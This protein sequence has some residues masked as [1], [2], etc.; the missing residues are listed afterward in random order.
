MSNFKIEK[1]NVE[2]MLGLTSMQEGMLF[3]YLANPGSKQYFE[4]FRL[5]LSGNIDPE[6][7][8]KAWEA[9][10]QTNEMLRTV[11][12]WEKLE[13]PIQVVL[14]KKEI[15]IEFKNLE[16]YGAKEKT[17]A[18][19]R[20]IDEDMNRPIEI[21][22]DPL[23]ITLIRMD[24]SEYRM[25]LT[26]HHIVY[27]GWSN[28][29][30][31]T[32]FLDAYH[33]LA[34]IEI[35]ELRP[36]SGS[37]L[38]KT[39]YKE[40]FKW[41]KQQFMIHNKEERETFW[42]AYLDGFDTCTS[43]PYNH[44][45]L[46][47]ISHVNTYPM[48]TDPSLYTAIET[49]TQQQNI[50]LSVLLYTA[51]GILL[52]KY[53]NADD[54]MFGTTVSGRVP[55][56][57][58]IDRMVGLFINTL[59]LRVNVTGDNSVYSAFQSISDHSKE[60]SRFEHTPL[61]EIKKYTGMGK[62]QDLFDSLIVI[63]NYPLAVEEPG[64]GENSSALKV[65]AFDMF[66][67][68]SFDITVQ[69]LPF[70]SRTM[71]IRFHFNSDLFEFETIQ[72]M[73]HH[74]LNVL[75]GITR[76][77]VGEISGI[78]MLSSEERKQ[79]LE[80]FNN[81]EVEYVVDKTVHGEIEKQVLRVPG[82]KAVQYEDKYITYMEFDTA[83]NR[84][85]HM[86]K[87]HGIKE[88]SRVAMMFPRSIEMITAVY[89]ILK[90]GAACIPLDI[91]YPDERNRFIVEDSGATILLKHPDVS[92]TAEPAVADMIYDTR[93]LMEFPEE[94]PG[95]VVK[96]TDLSYI[97]YTSGS[98]GKPKGAL[99][100]HS[101]IVNHT[102]TKIG[103]LGIT[104]KDSVGN[105]FSINVIASIW[106]ILS[107]LFMG[108]RLV[109][110]SDEIE[111]DPYAQFKRV[112]ED[113]VTVIEVIP[114]VLKSYLF[115]LEEGKEVVNLDGLR[116]VALTSEETKPFLVNKFYSLYKN[117]DMVDCYG[118]TECSDDVLHYTIPHDTNTQK[119]PI[120]TPSLNTQVMVLN[121]HNQLQPVGVVGEICVSGAGVCYGYWNRP[122]MNEEK[123]VS[124]PLNPEIRMYRT[125]DLGCWM[126][127]GKV[128]YLGRI[129]HQVKIRGNRVE[130]REIENRIIG[131]QD[132]KEA[133][134]VVKED[135]EGDKN[136]FCFF[137]SSKEITSP[138]IR[139]YLLD[140]LPDYMVPAHFIQLEKLPYTPNGKI[141]RKVLVKMEVETGVSTGVD[142][143]PPRNTY[144]TKI[145]EIWVQL[146][147]KPQIGMND[148]FFDLGGHS[149]LLI[150][151]KSKL[152][153][154]FNPDREISIIELFNYPTI[155]HQA[156][157]IQELLHIETKE[158]GV[159]KGEEREGEKGVITRDEDRDIAVIGISLKIPG[160]ASVEEFW[161]NII[162]GVESISFFDDGEI[163][164]SE[165]EGF[166]KGRSKVVN[167]GGIIGD[168]ELF[169]ADFFGFNPRE[170]EII[171]PQQ[172]L[173]L[174]HSWMALE[175]A[176]YGAIGETYGGNV[177]VYA[178]VGL[179]TYLL[180]NV[181]S[182]QQVV[183]T[184][185]EFQTMIGNDKD[186]LSTRVAYKLNLRG[187]AL[188]VQCACST[189]LVAVHLAR[190]GILTG[191][192]D[193]ALVG[194]VAVHVPEKTGYYYNEG[195]YLSPD[196]H[197]RAFDKDAQGTV[198]GNGIG[199]V[200]LKRLSKA[201]RDRDS[202][203]GIVKGSAINNDGSF[204]VGYTSPGETG[205]SQVIAKAIKEA[206][207]TSDTIGF[208]E[209][210][211]TGTV[212]GDPVEISALTRAHRSTHGKEKVKNGYCA[213]GSLKAN[214]GHL[215]IAAGIT[216]FIKAVLCLK[217]KKLPASINVTEPNPMIDFPNTPFYVNLTAKDWERGETPRRAGVSSFGIGGTNAH[218]ILEEAPG[219]EK[220]ISNTSKQQ[221]HLL[222]LSA[223]TDS[224]LENTKNRFVE[225]LK[226]NPSVDMGDVAN[227]LSL[228]RKAF[229]R[230]LAFVCNGAEDAREALETF[231][232]RRMIM[233]TRQSGEKSAVFMFPGIGEHYVNMAVGLYRT[234]PVFRKHVDNCC[235]LL[236]PLL[237]RDLR[238]I[239]FVEGLEKD[240]LKGNTDGA[241]GTQTVDFRKLV[242]TGGV[243]GD[244]LSEEEKTLSQT[245]YAH[246]SVFVV[247]Y[248]LAMLLMDWGIKPYAMIGYSVGEYTAACLSGVFSL[249]DALTA[250]AKRA[251]SIHGVE[252]GGMIAISLPEND[253]KPLLVDGVSI[254]AV[255]TP[256]LCVVS[257]T[258]AGIDTLENRLKEQKAIY[259]RL[260]TFQAFHSKMMELVRP[261]L[262]AIF[263]NIK[264]NPPTIPYMSNVTGD[265]ITPENK[266]VATG[267]YWVTHTVSPIRF[268]EGINRL[269]KTA[270]HFFIEVGP[271]NSLS[272]F[273]AQQ[274]K[275]LDSG[276]S[277]VADRFIMASLPK[278]SEKIPDDAFLFRAMGKMWAAGME[279]NWNKFYNRGEYKRISLPVYP[280][281]KKKY[282]LEAS[283]V[284]K[285][286]EGGMESSGQIGPVRIAKKEKIDQWFYLPSWKQSVQPLSGGSDGGTTVD[287]NWLVFIDDSP[288]GN[289]L[290]SQLKL[291]GSAENITVVKAGSSFLK[292]VRGVE[293]A[294]T[295]R[296]GEYD[297]YI[298]LLDDMG[299]N[300]KSFDTVV[301][302]WL[303]S[304]T[305]AMEDF[306]DRGV[307]S[308]L[309]LV[310]AMSSRSMF[311]HT[312]F[313]VISNYMHRIESSDI[314]NAGKAAIL[315]PL[316]VISQEYSNISCRSM[317]IGVY[318]Y[319]YE[320]RLDKD[321][322][323]EHTVDVVDS[324][325]AEFNS[326]SSDPVIAYRGGNR[327]VK[328]YE[329]LPSSRVPTGEGV[330][331]ILRENGVYLITGGLGKIGLSIAGYLAQTLK[332][333]I[334][335][336]SRSGMDGVI[337]DERKSA[338]IRQMEEDG[339]KILVLKADASNKE[340]MT[341]AVALAEEQFGKINGI[342]HAAG[343]MDE[344][345]FALIDQLD[346]KG[347]AGHFNPKIQGT[348]ILE[349]LFGDKELD[350]CILTSS[351][352]PILG[353]LSLFAY[354]SANSF[355]DHFAHQQALVNRRPWLSINWADWAQDESHMKAGVGTT[356]SALNI[357]REE[358]IETFKRVLN[359]KKLPQIVISSGDL[360]LR[361]KQWVLSSPEQKDEEAPRQVSIH[362]RPQLQSIYEAP[363]NE[364]EKI[365]T[366]IWQEL[367]GIDMVGVHDNFFELGG[368]SLIAT[369]L[370]S[371]L[372]EI[373]RI[374]IPLPTLFDRPT[375]REIVDYIVQT[376][377]DRDT[378]EE[379][380]K[381]Y[382]EVQS[383]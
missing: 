24:L 231:N 344:G 217:N 164:S 216:G 6:I 115:L 248:S 236:K 88:G 218:I 90:A 339:A 74:F 205:Q 271:G 148:N 327:W 211:G 193:M 9:V 365:L 102:Y 98:T 101:G 1:R 52:Q 370:I 29:I 296:P 331:P 168:I 131:Y 235:E 169:D 186:F 272:G 61:T 47:E 187:P 346:K 89:G 263:D 294:Y 256:D 125:G 162:N 180:N 279:I 66:E 59:P 348:M 146:L 367:L 247:E 26:F 275:N 225:F 39:P 173:F 307:Y 79:I 174:E 84:L 150:K 345:S 230:R 112:A 234:E 22:G 295:I 249:E 142:Y 126:E 140:I 63:D 83:A 127:D 91:S 220:N 305:P 355:M 129:D 280:F 268:S 308:M 320:H 72:R 62:D 151:L 261:Q 166:V 195:G 315:G 178:G 147:E 303:L 20:L 329:S 108:A 336:I 5:V 81:P 133:A 161:N 73:A 118:Q 170:A 333:R 78:E 144:E 291:K 352:S 265:W 11:I 176:G 312:D 119:V 27:D 34:G 104:E 141:D 113:G 353:G 349:E 95:I 51:W 134:V 116:K 190:Q 246:T 270:S 221:N 326:P 238:E 362:Q 143:Q 319:P 56:V 159:E 375:I 137:V 219:I 290:I 69:V 17:A 257:G 35:P 337:K 21:D 223:R 364:S 233:H 373:F 196:G 18:L 111:W 53:N 64:T 226:R 12:R 65:R 377:G 282:W 243:N 8:K 32:E 33:R 253:V 286:A 341:R 58:G 192:C 288:V 181:M 40:F 54:V 70:G 297:D 242:N 360:H 2:D 135:K 328:Y 43:L 109:V 191:D 298:A 171:E 57:K 369:R 68:T 314:C 36:E 197:C 106:Q 251:Q 207:I 306:L 259:R 41:Y 250:V 124:N 183:A 149:L 222:L 354:S 13:E 229:D 269:L 380:A 44:K 359:F 120:G 318:T 266:K 208:V 278:E 378:V 14:K 342:L 202:I 42:K 23:R 155:T 185:G 92:F 276:D 210:H 277:P 338:L 55:E 28:G 383:L 165:V 325:I 323:D 264:L 99:E 3:H 145:Q 163:E 153:K 136:L 372:R 194:G 15:L 204:K 203:Y 262:S 25:I 97:I 299:E 366:E 358:G 167:A 31:L 357:S 45:K 241:G 100:H 128:E 152:E 130:L 361:L 324:L 376:W 172:R 283:K 156:G 289:R 179:N 267:E 381:T 371:R 313:W 321:Y 71:D 67:M 87:E 351:L 132:M 177:G 7:F 244:N 317:D 254:A 281:E 245:I 227:T 335:L 76:P 293:A 189:S 105:N 237:G 260:K 157:F 228:G 122:E 49:V 284:A 285:Q 82:N 301:H 48:E 199:V 304:S 38:P 206:G 184:L 37:H 50:T 240:R 382:R 255:N 114:S 19:Q 175:D 374:D 252:Q 356:V 93:V 213:L 311:D 322:F 340:E 85:A 334:I 212:L 292:P 139:R 273:T 103:V 224:A 316:F 46:A 239:L 75:K 4:Q 300:D 182:N 16:E 310:K 96:P 343:V 209:T 214:V 330:P 347:C 309:Y 86:L 188:T 200:L 198:F 117:T 368:H 379:I 302:L 121:H 258:L 77:S 201:L 30:I 287:K 363:A 158:A 107:P 94:N 154:A 274:K 160:A 215:D 10:A 110:Y 123:Y 138:Q 350:F 232:P 80:V 60:R 332:A